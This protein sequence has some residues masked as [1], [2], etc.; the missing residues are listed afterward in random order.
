M[1]VTLTAVAVLLG[2]AVSAVALQ[3]RAIA[4]R[5]IYTACLAA[6][7]TI[8]TGAAQYLLSLT[9]TPQLASLPIGLPWVGVRLRVDQ[10]TAFF[11]VVVNLGASAASLFA[12]GYGQHEHAPG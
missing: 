11:Q 10:L 5:V 4:S 6:S 12:I 3:G 8:L 2:I 9:A 7:L 1:G